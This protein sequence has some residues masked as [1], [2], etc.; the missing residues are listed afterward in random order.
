MA[1]SQQP[2][3]LIVDSRDSSIIQQ[4]P[5]Y[6]PEGLSFP[7][8]SA[9]LTVVGVN[10]TTGFAFRVLA[11][12]AL[13]AVAI[14]PEDAATYTG[15]SRRLRVW[16]SSTT[17]V[18]DAMV[19]LPLGRFNLPTVVILQPGTE[20]TLGVDLLATDTIQPLPRA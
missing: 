5:T 15:V 4:G 6:G 7:Q 8:T 16:S 11:Q 13:L 14:D 10:V 9:S 1:H 3:L 19:P 17:V 20:Y 12:T 2:S 18:V